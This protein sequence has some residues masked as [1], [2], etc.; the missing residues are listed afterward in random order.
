MATGLHEIIKTG[1]ELKASDIHLE[2]GSP[3]YFRIQGQLKSSEEPLGHERIKNW[4]ADLLGPRMEAFRTEQS[5]DMSETIG[6]LRCRIHLF[7]SSRGL[8]ASIRLLNQEQPTLQSL[9]L[10]PNFQRIVD[11]RHGLVLVCGPTGSGKS[12]TIAA[13]LHEINSRSSANVITLEQ[14]IEYFYRN[15][16]SLIRQREVGRDT[17]SFEKGLIDAMRE[18]PDVIVVGEMRDKET[19]QLTLNAAETGHLVFATMHA[20]TVSE[21]LSRIL[22]AFP[23]EGRDNVA[24]QLAQV[25]Q[26]VVCQQ[27]SYLEKFQQRVP[28]C[29]LFFSTTGARAKIRSQELGSIPDSYYAG[30]D[31]GCMHAERYRQ[32]VEALTSLQKTKAEVLAQETPSAPSEVTKER[33]RQKKAPAR[34]SSDVYSIDEDDDLWSA[35]K[36]L[37]D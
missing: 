5:L 3:I 37:E 10:H 20:S 4:M 13:L 14:P 28:I 9:N 21:A 25:L 29:E 19:M 15:Q 32:W 2:S 34:E 24:A 31:A 1:R 18:D 17:P 27:L 26:V 36:S 12:S 11:V 7:H 22:K 23:A 35:I 33:Y 16:K 30:T 6:G 8:A